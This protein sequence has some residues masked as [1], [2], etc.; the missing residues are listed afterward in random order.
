MIFWLKVVISI[1][2]SVRNHPNIAPVLHL[3]EIAM[4]VYGNRFVYSGCHPGLIGLKL[5]LHGLYDSVYKPPTSVKAS[6]HL[7]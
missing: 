4:Y 7:V 3:C 2:K 6:F 5:S 1:S